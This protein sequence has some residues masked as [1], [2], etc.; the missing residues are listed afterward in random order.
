MR[1]AAGKPVTGEKD[2]FS[3]AVLGGR[4]CFKKLKERGRRMLSS[5][6]FFILNQVAR[7]V[8]LNT[9]HRWDQMTRIEVLIAA[10]P[11]GISWD[12]CCC[13][14]TALLVCPECSYKMTADHNLRIA[15]NQTICEK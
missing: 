8:T 9:L 11:D 4:C 13:G 14:R 3:S 15:F 6:G 7:A 12:L 5:P 1:G 10:G 2:F